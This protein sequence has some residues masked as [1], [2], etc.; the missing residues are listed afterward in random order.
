MQRTW[1]NELSALPI[2]ESCNLHRKYE[3]ASDLLTAKQAGATSTSGR[4]SEIR[5]NGTLI[6]PFQTSFPSDKDAPF[7][8]HRL[9]LN[10][11][12]EVA[13]LLVELGPAKSIVPA[14]AMFSAAAQEL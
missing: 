10:M 3:Q 6:G 7:L 1:K 4:A 9:L 11:A 14:A 8:F 12:L 2:A 13:N 5:S